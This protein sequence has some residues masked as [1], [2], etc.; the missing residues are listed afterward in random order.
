VSDAQFT[1]EDSAWV[2][3]AVKSRAGGAVL[4][5]RGAIITMDTCVLAA[6]AIQDSNGAGGAVYLRNKATLRATGKCVCCW[7]CR[8]CLNDATNTN[9]QYMWYSTMIRH[10]DTP[11]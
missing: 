5:E 8:Y 1:A 3:N 11:P 9:A 2:G 6:N 4:G 10:R 7:W